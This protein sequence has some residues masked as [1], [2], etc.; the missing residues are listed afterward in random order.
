M[1]TEA[2]QSRIP[3]R[4]VRNVQYTMR[5][6]PRV[7]VA[8]RTNIDSHADLSGNHAIASTL[9]NPYCEGTS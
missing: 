4:G 1:S 3:P 5:A 7:A 6:R 2:A 8:L 9:R